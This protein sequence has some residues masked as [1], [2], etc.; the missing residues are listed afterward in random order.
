[1]DKSTK[2][3]K[4][5]KNNCLSSQFYVKDKTT[6]RLDTTCKDCRKKGSL[7]NYLGN[8]ERREAVKKI[9]YEKNRDANIEKMRQRHKIRMERFPE[10]ERATRKAWK[11]ANR[12]KAL[13]SAKKHHAK[14]KNDPEYLLKRANRER[15]LKLLA[16]KKGSSI[17]LLGASVPLIR[18][19]LEGQFS[20]DMNWENHGSV[21]HIDHFYP[22]TS[23]C[24]TDPK[25]SSKCFNW[26]NIQPLTVHDNISKN[27]KL[28]T[29]S[30]I[31][32]MEEKCRLFAEEHSIALKS[33]AP[34]VKRTYCTGEKA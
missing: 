34:A 1:M 25:E 23:Y 15:V 6:G 28:P 12:A 21:W 26:A 5:C 8:L 27:N 31:Q 10:E 3:C 19:W 7:A 13:L 29:S 16:S 24:L 2:L 4:A 33:T 22:C 9:W 20:S 18:L 32:H 14:M 17:D 11:Q 30:Q